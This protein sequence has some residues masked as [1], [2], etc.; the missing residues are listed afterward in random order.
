MARKKLGEMLLEAGVID[1]TGL[2]AALVEQR[3]WGGHL[4]RVLIDM[5]LVTEEQLV[6]IL[7][8]QLGIA[9]V[10]V[11]K[12]EIG[13]AVLDLVPGELAEQFSLIPFAQ[14]M[15]FLDVAMSDPTNLG[16]IDEL[17]IRT[18]LNVRPYLAGPRTIERAVARYYGRGI[19]ATSAARSASLDLEPEPSRPMEVIRGGTH[20]PPFATPSAP[21]PSPL[22][23]P[24]PGRANRDA[25]ITALQER[26]SKLEA[27]VQRDEDVL[28]KV[29]AL[30]VEKGVAT[31]EEILERLR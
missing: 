17:R 25:E 2:R 1:Q 27:L 6:S 3:R 19:M 24:S 20:P 4:G 21:G 23:L 18:Q 13:Q 22:D 5:K 30:L 12:L 15:K 11:D 26:L 16:I 7:S 14:P 31:R 8:R 9:T 28:R 10:D 29:L